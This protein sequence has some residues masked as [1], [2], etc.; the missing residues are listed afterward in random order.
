MPPRDTPSRFFVYVATAGDSRIAVLEMSSATEPPQVIQRVDLERHADVG[1]FSTPMSLSSDGRFLYVALR[2]PPL[3]VVCFAVDRFDGRLSEVGSGR[4][5]ASTPYIL[6]DGS[7]RFLFSVANPGATLAI[8][9]IEIDGRIAERA[10]QVL[11]I[12]HKLHCIAIDENNRF[13]YVSSTDDRRIFQYRFDAA[14]GR[15]EPNHPPAVQLLDDGDP[16]HLRFSR[17]GRLMYATTEA[18]G[19]V[20]SFA[21]DPVSGRLTEL[22][23]TA[24]MPPSHTGRASAADLH[25]TP[26]GRFLYATERALNRIV[27]YRVDGVTGELTDIEALETETTPRAF[28]IA[29]NGGSLLVA[30]AGSGQISAYT[31]DPTSGRLEKGVEFAT[32]PN[33]NWIEF[34]EPGVPTDGWYPGSRSHEPG[35]GALAATPWPYRNDG[36]CLETGGQCLSGTP[37]RT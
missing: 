9:R 37:E 3:P 21:V 7:G 22:R 4:L 12:G 11:H 13:V 1:G 28:A 14:S 29:P 19:Q 23:R 36:P 8:N 26:D 34:V 30:G 16:R 15:L 27:A 32:G 6:T 33:P 2:T 24:M 10:H 5:P 25:L 31:I 35:S 20:V 18:G 17:D